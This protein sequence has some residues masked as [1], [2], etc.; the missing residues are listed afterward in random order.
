MTTHIKPGTVLLRP[1]VTEKA[2]LK[3]DS[4][5]VYVFEVTKTATKKSII[6]SI[7]DAFNVTPVKVRLL[8]IPTKAVFRRGKAGSK[9]GGKKAYIHLKKGDK[10]DVM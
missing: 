10:I 7:K 4:S 8:A 2:A 3:A 9:G 5:N 1:R 6:A